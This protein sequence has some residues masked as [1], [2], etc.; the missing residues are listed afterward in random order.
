MPFQRERIKSTFKE[1]VALWGEAKGE[2]HS[3][4]GG[5]AGIGW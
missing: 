1:E 4:R 5:Q 2:N 3:F